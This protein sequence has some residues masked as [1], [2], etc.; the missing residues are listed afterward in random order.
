MRTS[1]RQY[2]DAGFEWDE[3]LTREVERHRELWLGVERSMRSVIQK[4]G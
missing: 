1:Y 4:R 2:W 3:Y